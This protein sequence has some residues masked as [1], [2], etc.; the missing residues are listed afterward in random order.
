MGEISVL[1]ATPCDE[2]GRAIVITPDL[3]RHARASHRLMYVNNRGWHMFRLAS[4]LSNHNLELRTRWTR[5]RGWQRIPHFFGDYI[6]IG[7][8]SI[9]PQQQPKLSL[10]WRGECQI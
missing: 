10:R 4:S 2:D 7:N 8:E 3:A 6:H 9:G 5:G 1:I